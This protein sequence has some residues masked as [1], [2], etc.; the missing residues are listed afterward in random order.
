MENRPIKVTVAYSNRAR[1]RGR[2]RR[3]RGGYDG[4]IGS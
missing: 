1:G 2:G 3:G 4:D